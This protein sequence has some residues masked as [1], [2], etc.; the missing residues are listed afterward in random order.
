MDFRVPAMCLLQR[1]VRAS[2]THHTVQNIVHRFAYSDEYVHHCCLGPRKAFTIS[3][4]LRVFMLRWNLLRL[5]A[6]PKAPA[7]R[8]R[9]NAGSAH[10]QCCMYRQQRFATRECGLCARS[11]TCFDA[12]SEL[13]EGLRMLCGFT[14]GQYTHAS[15]AALSLRAWHEHSTI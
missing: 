10:S 8:G 6:G 11:C 9:M 15:A 12:R 1:D 5:S 14:S 4:Q 3:V 7:E 2:D 13:L